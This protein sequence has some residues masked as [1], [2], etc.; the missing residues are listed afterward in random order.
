MLEP[1]IF[2]PF[3]DDAD[4]GEEASGFSSASASGPLDPEKLPKIEVVGLSVGEEDGHSDSIVHEAAAVDEGAGNASPAGSEAAA[5]TREGDERA[6]LAEGRADVDPDKTADLGGLD[7]FL[8][9]P[10][11]VPPQSSWRSGDTMQMPRVGDAQGSQPQR[12]FR[13][14]DPNAK[15][16]LFGRSGKAKK[17]KAEKDAQGQPEETPAVP[18]DTGSFTASSL[19]LVQ[20]KPKKKGAGRKRHVLG[21]VVLLV[22]ASVAAAGVTYGMELWGGKTVPDVSGLTQSDATYMLE[23]KGFTVR[24]TQVKSDDTEGLVLLVDPAVGSRAQEGSE[25]VIHVSV[26]R[27]IPDVSGKTK[28]EALAALEAEGFENVSIEEQK[29]NDEEGMAVSVTPEAGSKAKAAAEV[30]LTVTVPY[31]VPEVAGKTWNDAVSALEGEGY[32]YSVEYVY[33]DSVVEGTILG[34][35]PAAGEKLD[36]GSTVVMQ[37][38]RSRGSELVAAAQSYL[39]SAGTV[40]IGGTQYSITSVDSVTYQGNDTT[41]FTITGSAETVLDGETVRGSSR[42]KT[43]SIVWDSNNNVVSIS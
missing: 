23:S 39:Q 24:E 30:R 2:G 14:P 28:D 20:E 41:S 19:D 22:L 37:V 1:V 42:Q 18:S 31:Y 8:I 5:A 29:S 25:V 16:G 35:S 26:S 17:K 10:G 9:G 36:S 6:G 21:A 12:D 33:D 38:S 7:E 27:T 32:S 3:R 15:K 13:A 43:G 4:P 11:Y 34:S 40:T